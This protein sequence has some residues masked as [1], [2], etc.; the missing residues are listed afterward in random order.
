MYSGWSSVTPEVKESISFGKTLSAYPNHASK[1]IVH[2]VLKA[3]SEAPKAKDLP[4]SLETH[5]Q[6]RWTMDVLGYSLTLPLSEHTLIHLSV[7]IYQVW[8]SAIFRPQKSVPKPVKEN[9]ASYLQDILK[10]LSQ[11]FFPRIEASHSVNHGLSS[12]TVQVNLENQAVLCKNVL[13]IYKTVIEEGHD[14]KMTRELWECLLCCLLRVANIVLSPPSSPHNMAAIL[15]ALPVKVLFEGWLQA[16]VTHF[17]R[18]QLWKSLLELCCEWRHHRSLINQWTHMVYTLT[19]QVIS[20]MYH[21]DLAKYFRDPPAGLDSEYQ[22]IISHMSYETL[23]QCW[24]RMLHTLGNPVELSYPHI[25]TNLPAFRKLQQ[26][27]LLQQQQHKNSDP[28]HTTLVSLP[29]TYYDL[30]K[31]VATLVYLFLGQ[32]VQWIEWEDVDGEDP[33]RTG[34]IKGTKVTV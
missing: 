27:Y 28:I 18:P 3:L 19:Y 10:Q 12:S 9:P 26:E 23:I 11:V 30:M 24:Y 32:D 1:E 33:K 4:I 20:M 22:M 14:R 6:V 34:S 29:R 16:S 8:V 2:T 17:P 31:G 7:D 13:K 21:S 25:I 15:K 5:E